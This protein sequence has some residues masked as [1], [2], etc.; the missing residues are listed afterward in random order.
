MI[1]NSNRSDDKNPVVKL[2]ARD[3]IRKNQSSF[4]AAKTSTQNSERRTSRASA[5]DKHEIKQRK[6]S[7]NSVS[8]DNFRNQK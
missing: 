7:P 1:P 6:S 3:Q 2:S 5:Y 4:R 8:P